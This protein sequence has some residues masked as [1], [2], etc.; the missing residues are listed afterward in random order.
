MAI[1]KLAQAAKKRGI[2]YER[3]ELL[4]T[5]RGLTPEGI[6]VLPDSQ[7]RSIARR[8]DYADMPNARLAWRRNQETGDD[9]R[10]AGD[11]LIKALRELDSIRA[12]TIARAVAGMATGLPIAAAGPL[13]AGLAG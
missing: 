6:E 1:R 9:G 5:S 2:S 11:S 4:Y 12:R 10:I 13:V 7:L 8:L 3:A